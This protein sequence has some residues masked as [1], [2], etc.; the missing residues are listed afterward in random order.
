MATAGAKTAETATDPGATQK[1]DAER[2]MHTV[3]P[4]LVCAGAAKA[5][6]FYKEAFGA[7]E[8]MRLEGPDGRLWHGCVRIGDSLVMLADEMPDFGSLGPKALKGTTVTIHLNVP[9]V[10]AFTE[11]AVAAGANVV[12]PIADAFWGDRYGQ[13]EDPFGH[14]WSI[15]TR[16][17]DMTPA[18]I[19]AAMPTSVGCG[20]EAK[21]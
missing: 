19:R 4:H 16:V 18:E 3:T 15:A 12:M 11:R 1:S 5:I 21:E 8:M 6:D 9:D 14:R 7:E 10:D 20:P 17:K 13:I 2:C